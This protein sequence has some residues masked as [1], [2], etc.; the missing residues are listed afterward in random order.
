[1]DSFNE[2]LKVLDLNDDYDLSVLIDK[3][4]NTLKETLQQ[5]APQK[6]RIITLRPLSPWYNDHHGTMRRLVKK[7]EIAGN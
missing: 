3:Y 5:H 2:D 6:R 1:M 7:K 4:E